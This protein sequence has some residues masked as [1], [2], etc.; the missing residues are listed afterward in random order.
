MN[1]LSNAGKE[2]TVEGRKEAGWLGGWWEWKSGVG[3]HSRDDESSQCAVSNPASCHSKTVM[4]ALCPRFEWW[5]QGC[6]GLRVVGTGPLRMLSRSLRHLPAT[7][8]AAG[9]T[10]VGVSFCA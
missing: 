3:R 4:P 6:P 1:E 7:S 2:K 9:L 8:P 5:A 10:A